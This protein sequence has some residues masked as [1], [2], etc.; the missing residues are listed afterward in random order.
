MG[1]VVFKHSEKLSKNIIKILNFSQFNSLLFLGVRS[2][3]HFESIYL[4]LLIM[5]NLNLMSMDTLL[6][7]SLSNH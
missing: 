7:R 6:H 4:K 2:Y 5:F 1:I 3:N